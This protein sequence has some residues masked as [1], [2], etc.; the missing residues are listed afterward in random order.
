M[1]LHFSDVT[2]LFSFVILRWSAVTLL[3]PDAKLLFC[4]I[5]LRWYDV[6]LLS[7]VAELLFNDVV[8]H[9]SMLEYK[10]N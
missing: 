2:L 6:S 3:S 8:L 4:D 5:N 7:F 9:S 1:E 10:L